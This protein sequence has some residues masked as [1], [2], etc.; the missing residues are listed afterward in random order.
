MKMWKLAGNGKQYEIKAV[1]VADIKNLTK[2]NCYTT[3]NGI[4]EGIFEDSP[5]V[6]IIGDNGKLIK[7]IHANRFE[8][9]KEVE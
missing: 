5:Y 4:E 6:S 3:I 9:V 1:G 2:D 7:G 8:I